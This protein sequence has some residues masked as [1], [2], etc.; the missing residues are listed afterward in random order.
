[1]DFK[2]LEVI[3][4]F[5]KEIKSLNLNSTKN[6]KEVCLKTESQPYMTIINKLPSAEV[7]YMNQLSIDYCGIDNKKARTMGFKFINLF[8]HK[9]NLA[10]IYYGLEHFALNP[11]EPLRMSWKI[12]LPDS[13]ENRWIF[14]IS[15]AI[16]LHDENKSVQGAKYILSF[17]KDINSLFEEDRAFRMLKKKHSQIDAHL[18][19]FNTLTKR[20]KVILK[21]IVEECTSE[22]IGELLDISANTVKTYRQNIIKKLGV[23]TS[24]GLGKFAWLFEME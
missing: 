7:E 3:E 23:K 10:S 5:I 11:K 21:M 19:K 18:D 2:G 1:M 24:V 12:K 20:E 15:Y 4:R 22:K 17:V 9:D 13:G 6:L 8:I 16:Q 14:V